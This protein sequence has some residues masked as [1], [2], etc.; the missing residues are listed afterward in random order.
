MLYNWTW[1]RRVMPDNGE[2]NGLYC[3]VM[4]QYGG[5]YLGIIMDEHRCI[6]CFK[7]WHV[8]GFYSCIT[9]G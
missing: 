6:L 4:D 5:L 3:N 8:G 9:M 7:M 2:E 1:W